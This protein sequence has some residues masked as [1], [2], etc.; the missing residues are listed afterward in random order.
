MPFHC[1]VCKL[2]FRFENELEQHMK[3]EH[4]DFQADKEYER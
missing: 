2:I 4:P 3:D 1:P